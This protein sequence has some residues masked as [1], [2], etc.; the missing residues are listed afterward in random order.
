MKILKYLVLFLSLTGF[1][2]ANNEKVTPKEIQAHLKSALP[3][4]W[5]MIYD[6]KSLVIYREKEVRFLNPYGLPGSET[7]EK[8]FKEFGWNDHLMIKLHFVRK[9]EEKEFKEV[10]DLRDQKLN[11]LKENK[12]LSGKSKLSLQWKIEE[13]FLVPKYYNRDYS[14]YIHRTDKEL[15]SIWPQSVEK[16]FVDI[17]K[18]LKETFKE[19]P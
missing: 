17:L 14:I 7:L 1:V 9:Y 2:K 8:A 15:F 16:E 13:K 11:K 10:K 6:Y 3:K 12:K 4:G 18:K 19:Y 5:R